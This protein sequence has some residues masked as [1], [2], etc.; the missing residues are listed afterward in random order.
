MMGRCTRGPRWRRAAIGLVAS[1]QLAQVAC[2]T[3][4]GGGT[5][6][7]AIGGEPGRADDPEGPQEG[8]NFGDLRARLERLRT[9]AA[10]VEP[11]ATGDAGKCEDLCSIATNICAVQEKLCELADEHPG[12]D[13]YQ[14]LCREA[15]SECREAQDSCVRC[16]ESN[17]RK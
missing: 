13:E 15:K 11:V 17:S 16:V 10:A 2:R 9:R 14:A 3:Q 4:S 7:P 5:V 1:L 8:E 6:T 12:E